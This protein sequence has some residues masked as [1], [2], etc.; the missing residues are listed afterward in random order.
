VHWVARLTHNVLVVGLSPI[1]G[2]PLFVKQE[3]L[4]LFLSTVWFQKPD[5]SVISQSN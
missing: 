4:P 3:T 5:S 1:K 2:P